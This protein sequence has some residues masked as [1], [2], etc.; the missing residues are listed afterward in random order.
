[1]SGGSYDYFYARID[2]FADEIRDTGNPLRDAFRIHLGKVAK[3]A[4]A[5]EWADSGDWEESDAE[6]AISECLK[7]EAP[8]LLEKAVLDRLVRARESL[9]QAITHLTPP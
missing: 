5:I 4:K 9:D 1:M 8:D 7:G 2:N 3:A 6:E